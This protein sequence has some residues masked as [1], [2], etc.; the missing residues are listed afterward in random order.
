MEIQSDQIGDIL[1]AIPENHGILFT[2]KDADMLL[3]GIKPEA[4]NN[5]PKDYIHCVGLATRPFVKYF[6]TYLEH[7]HF[8]PG[9]PINDEYQF[10]MIRWQGLVWTVCSIPLSKKHLCYEVAKE[11]KLKLAN[12]IPFKTGIILGARR[13]ELT[14]TIPSEL[15]KWFPINGE[16][17]FTLENLDGNPI[18]EGMGGKQDVEAEENLKLQK[19]REKGYKV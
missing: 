15:I 12:G 18:Y 6:C 3:W 8:T 10:R 5:V 1:D 11:A 4:L 2:K 9:E 14:K 13:P 16:N 7:V 19:L 17:V